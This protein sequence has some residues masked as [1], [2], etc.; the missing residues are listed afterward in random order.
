MPE[1][2]VIR[3]EGSNQPPASRYYPICAMCGGV[4]LITNGL[5]AEHNRD[6]TLAMLE[7]GDFDGTV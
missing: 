2:I 3:C 1:P 6:D 5:V 7:R 4:Y